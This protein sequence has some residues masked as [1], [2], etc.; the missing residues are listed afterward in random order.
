MHVFSPDLLKQILREA[1]VARFYLDEFC[2]ASSMTRLE[3]E[4]S[5]IFMS[6]KTPLSLEDLQKKLPYVPPKK[7]FMALS[8]SKKF[9]KTNSGKFIPLSKIRFDSDE[10]RAAASQISSCID[11]NGFANPEDYSLSENFALNPEIA[12]KDL[13]TA[14]FEEFFASTFIRRGKKLFRKG[15]AVKDECLPAPSSTLRKFIDKQEEFSDLK[16]FAVAE[17]LGI[18]QREALQIAY[19]K[20]VR[21]SKNLFV[22]DTLI[23][24]DVAGVDEALAPFVQN[25]IVSLRSVTSFTGFPYVAGCTWNL[26]LLESFLRKY[27]RRYTYAAPTANSSN[28]GAIFPKTM[29]FKDYHDVQ[30]AAVA[31]ENIP[32][33]KSNIENFLLQQ[34]FRAKKVPRMTE[35]IISRIQKFLNK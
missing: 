7:I 11:S 34:G 12:E 15:A 5:K 33:E 32:L 2:S 8:N 19:E 35:R 30:A 1:D 3:Y 23:N 21:V 31:Q 25:K 18:Y 6:A 17:N 22:A 14:I 26:F 13:R 9:L 10:I 20:M 16:L 28:V 4:I 24:F 27:S 29:K